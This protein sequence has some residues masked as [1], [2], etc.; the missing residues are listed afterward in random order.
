MLTKGG[1]ARP[2]DA[3]SAIEEIRHPLV[4]EFLDLRDEYSES[5]L[6]L[7]KAQKKKLKIGTLFGIELVDSVTRLCAMNLLLQ[8]T[9]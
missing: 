3:V 6:G 5:A 2:G 9:S 1:K 4:L 7:D 8:D